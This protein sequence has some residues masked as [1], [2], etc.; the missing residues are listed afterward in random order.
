MLSCGSN[1]LRISFATPSKSTPSECCLSKLHFAK[2]VE[3]TQQGHSV[4]VATRA[5][6]GGRKKHVLMGSVLMGSEEKA[7]EPPVKTQK[8]C[9][10]AHFPPGNH[11]D[12]NSYLSQPFYSSHTGYFCH[13]I[14]SSGKIK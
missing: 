10:S 13:Q 4:E 8:H 3:S 11:S 5:T 9:L 14:H 7:L 12:V 6:G 2:A 1:F